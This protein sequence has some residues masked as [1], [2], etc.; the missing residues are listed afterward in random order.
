VE[1]VWRSRGGAGGSAWQRRRPS[2]GRTGHRRRECASWGGALLLW[3]GL[4]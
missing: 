1:R 4:G 3:G 2:W